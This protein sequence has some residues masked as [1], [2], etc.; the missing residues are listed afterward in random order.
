NFSYPGQDTAKSLIEDDTFYSMNLLKKGAS[1]GYAP[2]S[3]LC[4]ICSCPLT[5]TFTA[6]RVRVFNCGHATHLQCEP[7]ENETSSSSSSVHVSSSGCPVCMTKK[8]SKSSSKGKSFYLDYGLIST[9]SSNAGSAQ[10]AS[11]YLHEN[12]M[13]NHSHNQQISR[14]EILTNLQ[15]D[16]RLVQI[17]SLPRLRLAPPAVYHEKVSRFSGFTPGESSS[18]K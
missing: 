15:K 11:P 4:C 8:T 5:K 9:V 10:R 2:R 7:S 1:H 16:Q 13:S 12:E 17:E 6:L 18:G 14:F 3:L